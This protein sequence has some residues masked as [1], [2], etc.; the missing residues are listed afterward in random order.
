M[1]SGI[2]SHRLSETEWL[3]AQR[4]CTDKQ[5]HALDYWRRGWGYRSISVQLDIN[6]SSAKS[7]IDSAR[8]NIG[9]ALEQE[10]LA[11]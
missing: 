6:P 2:T 8:R 5:I 1:I 7:R 4:V 3:V 11:A 9:R 10:L